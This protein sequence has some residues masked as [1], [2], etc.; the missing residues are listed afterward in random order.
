MAT[1]NERQ[2]RFAIGRS[3][4]RLAD[5][6]DCQIRV[7]AHESGLSAAIEQIC[8]IVSRLMRVLNE[9]AANHRSHKGARVTEA[10]IVV[11]GTGF[12]G[13]GAGYRLE[14]DGHPYVVYDRNAYIGGHTSSHKLP[15]GFIFDEGPHVSF[16]KDKR[17]QQILADAVGGRYEDVRMGLDSYWEGRILTHPLQVNL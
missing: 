15:G 2:A 17:V 6:L 13:F 5:T 7:F 11:V 12:A 16:T 3:I 8:E 1:M 14:A 10:P 4:S 9:S